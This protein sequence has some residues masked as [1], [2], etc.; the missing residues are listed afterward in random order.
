[1]DELISF[2]ANR[3]R[4]FDTRLLISPGTKPVTRATLRA[5]WDDLFA[6]FNGDVLF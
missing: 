1:M 6:G 2:H 3:S 5:A 4:N